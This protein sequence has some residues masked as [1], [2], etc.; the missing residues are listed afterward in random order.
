MPVSNKYRKYNN[1]SKGQ[2]R[3]KR[4]EE[5]HPSRFVHTAEYQRERYHRL[6]DTAGCHSSIRIFY[7]GLK[8][9]EALKEAEVIEI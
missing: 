4:Y 3:R 9:I 8:L 1:S 2:A 6:Q 5:K 7:P